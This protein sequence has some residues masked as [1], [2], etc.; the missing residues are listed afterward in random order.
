[1]KSLA[2]LVMVV[3]VV[4][5]D[6]FTDLIKE[7]WNAFKLRHKKS[8]ED[9]TEDKFRMKIFAENKL[10]IEKHNR[11]FESGQETYRLGV[12]KYADMLH[13]EFVTMNEFNSSAKLDEGQASSG[14]TFVLPAN[15][16]VPKMMDW[17][18]HGAVT[19]V[20]DQGKCGSSWAF[21]TTGSLEAKHFLKTGY[22][23]S[24]SE[25]NLIDCSGAYGNKGC[26]G[27][28]VANSFTYIRDNGGINTEETYPYKGVSRL[29]RYDPDDVGATVVGFVDLPKGDEKTLKQAVA[30]VGPVSVTIDASERAFQFYTTGVYYEKKC[31]SKKVNHAMLVVGYGTDDEHDDYWLLKNSWGRS[32]GRLGYMQLARNRDNHCGVATAATYPLV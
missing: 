3:V 24:L 1:M 2:V 7:E 19:D 29:C 31:S 17:R 15:L 5:A 14:A 11:R 13:H 25:Q 12:N 28:F 23:W 26:K 27:G 8:Y 6:T 20:K 10:Y 4:V 16:A 22:L 30:T 32:W 21:S 9:Q 18:K